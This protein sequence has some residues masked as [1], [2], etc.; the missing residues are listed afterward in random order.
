MLLSRRIK[1]GQRAP[2]RR[3]SSAKMSGKAIGILNKP[4]SFY[5][6]VEESV[7]E[8]RGG[9]DCSFRGHV[10]ISFVLRFMANARP[11]EKWNNKDERLINQPSKDSMLKEQA[12]DG[13]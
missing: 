10:V 4:L 2:C 5:C 8:E 12:T 1:H 7:D 11:T 3:S 9:G 6:A 13:G